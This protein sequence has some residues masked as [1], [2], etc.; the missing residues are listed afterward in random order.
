[1]R[2][3][4]KWFGDVYLR[5]TFRNSAGDVVA[6]A[7]QV[8]EGSVDHTVW[9]P[10]ELLNLPRPAYFATSETK[11][12]D[13]AAAAAAAL[14]L[15]YLDFRDT[16]LSYANRCLDTAKALYRFAVANRGLGYSGGFY[17]SS[18]DNDEMAWAAVWLHTATGE[19]SYLTDITS[20]AD[21]RYTGYLKRIIQSTQDNWQ[22][23]WVHSWDTVWGGVFVQ[24]ANVLPDDAQFDYYA[25]WNLEYWSGGEVPHRESNDTTYM[26]QTPAGFSVISTWG[27]ARYNAA[28]QMCALIYAKHTG[29]NEFAAWAR[30]QMAYIM[31]DN[32]FGY[33]L[34]VGYPTPELSAKHP[35]HRAAHG[36]TTNSMNDPP[37]HKHVLW[38]ALVGGPDGKDVHVDRTDDFVYNEVAIDYNA[39]LVG[40]LAGLYS[41]YGAGQLPIASF[42]PAEPTEQAYTAKGK[43]EQENNQRSQITITM[44]AQPT[45]PPHF[46]HGLSARYFFDISELVAAGQTISA[47]T[48]A[49][50][51]DEQASGYGGS[52][53]LRGPVAW[54]E[55]NG[56]YYM[57]VDWGANDVY[58]K[59][60]LQLALI[61]AQ[62]AQWK[63]NW[64]PTNDWS[65]QGLSSTAS[66]ATEYI[67]IYLDGVKVF[68]QEP[69]RGGTTTFALTVTRAG[70][71]AGT[72]TSSTGGINCGSTCSAT[73]AS[74]AVVTLT[75]TATSPSTFGGWSGACSGT[76][77]TCV[78]TMSAARSVTATFNG[79]QQTYALTVTKAGTGGGTVTSSTG[80]I[81][82]GTTCSA[83]Y[84]SGAVVTLTAAATSPSTFGGWSGACSGTAAT[85][86]LTMSAARS[87]TAT[88]NATYGITLTIT[89]AG[90]GTGTVTSN[91]G[92]INCGT[93]CSA[94]YASGT[95]VTL[96]RAVSTGSTFGGWSGAGCSGTGATCVVTMSQSR[97]VTATFNGTPSYTLTVTKAGTGAGTVTSS[98]GGINCGSTCS[99]TYAS[100]TVVTLT[101]AATSP[102]TFGGWSGACTNA[103][104]TCTVTMS[105]AR[106][107]TAT[108]NPGTTTTPCANPVTIT[109]GQSGNFNTDGAICLRTSANV[110]GWGCANFQGR[111]VSVN[112]GTASATCGGGAVPLPKWSDGYTYFAITAG[113]YPWASLYYW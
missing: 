58:G 30:G 71:G 73:F 14:A 92:G 45:H 85:C 97:T 49:V 10:P 72:V 113:S 87:V 102:S 74:G 67:P 37:N 111:T 54:D 110:Y 23:I 55:A 16:D 80:G 32:P 84:A 50:Y 19:A 9:A 61:A 66:T 109:G 25:R 35:H 18:D 82:C 44:T 108:F 2:E 93:A 40:A 21:G 86:V 60:D 69:P 63:S 98:T 20:I 8:G 11:A 5:S 64:D 79:Q 75:A 36:S 34:I 106:S 47:V 51:Y 38:G 41:F 77:A 81:N 33:S 22:N 31:G 100:G 7:Y 57:E 76:A 107:V 13:Q 52:T 3:L 12:S 89:K 48:S 70:T 15:L 29:R 28:A 1:M 43:I 6:F 88:F 39:G 94:T 103:T 90:T 4:L 59:R 53:V 78:L 104:G 27:S 26:A 105:Q 91:I 99:A 112:G 101:A 83:N 95:Q 24:L 68:G 96:T 17:N 65:H 62:D 56:V 42:P 46:V